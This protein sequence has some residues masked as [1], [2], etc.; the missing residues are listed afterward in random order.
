MGRLHQFLRFLASGAVNTAAS[1]AVFLAL[2]PFT[3]YLV[4]YSI[5][6]AFGIALSYLLMTRFVFRKAARLATAM[7]FPLVYVVQYALGSAVTYAL[8]EYA[9]VRPFIAALGAIV[10]TIPVTF[11]LA[12][13][14][15]RA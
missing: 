13:T 8:V 2:L 15:F 3:H 14:I 11:I 4:A 10:A 9:H 12:R 7:R 1:Y 5:G 6:Y